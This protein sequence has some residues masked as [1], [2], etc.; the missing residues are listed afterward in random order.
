MTVTAR[1]GQLAAASAAMGSIVTFTAV[2]LTRTAS[3][4]PFDALVHGFGSYTRVS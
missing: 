3:V 4:T 1:S 2:T